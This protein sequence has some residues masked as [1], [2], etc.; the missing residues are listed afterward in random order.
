[1]NPSGASTRQ[2]AD[3]SLNPLLY[4]AIVKMALL[5][6]LGGGDVTTNA[7]V[8]TDQRTKAT[9]TAKQPGVVAGLDVAASAFGLL[10]PRLKF[11][12]LA[13]DGEEVARGQIVALVE[14]PTRSLLSAERTALNFLQ[15]LSGIA[16]ATRL[17]VERVRP[18]KARILDTR[19]T[20]PGLRLLEK[21]A[22]KLGGGL[23]HRF[24]LGDAVMIK[25][26]HIVAAGGIAAA[27]QLVRKQLGP[28]LKVEVETESLAQVEEALQ[29]GADVI[30]LDNMPLELMREAVK[31][32]DGRALT[33]ASGGITLETLPE[34]AA[35]GVDFISLGWLTHSSRALDISLRLV[36]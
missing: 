6:D 4:E 22:V 18:F 3:A 5:E 27:L 7:T 9:L 29:A 20:T 26:N 8:G 16:T 17:A 34:V 35:T 31:L 23:N 24:G 10:D 32:V 25:D 28:L 11:S 2:G 14:G 19:K 1:M 12:A 33:E 15:R 30:M 36:S 13:A 21:Y